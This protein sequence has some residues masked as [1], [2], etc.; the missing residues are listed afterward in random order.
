MSMNGLE[1]SRAYFSEAIRPILAERVP[2]ISQSYAAAL[3][4]WG[5]DVLGNDDELSR[6]HEWGPRCLLFV[7]GSLIRHKGK[8]LDELNRHLPME[9]KGHATR[10]VTD[11][12][13]PTVR[14]PTRDSAGRV[15]IEVTTC[16]EY[17][18]QSIGTVVPKS[19][20]EWLTIPE[21]T[22]LE[23][24][25][26]E[27]F[28]DGFGEL[29]RQRTYYAYFPLDVWKYRLAYTWQA[30]GWDIDLIG[31]C[32]MRGDILSARYGVSMSAYW[33][34]RLVFLLNR[35]YCPL[36]VKWF[37][38]E[39]YKLGHLA[40]EIGPVLEDSYRMDDLALVP[41]R[42][43]AAC[44]LLIEHQDSLGLLPN[45]ADMPHRSYRGFAY[46]EC[47]AIANRIKD[48]VEGELRD[49]SLDGALDQWVG[50]YDLLIEAGKLESLRKVYG[51]P[52]YTRT[53]PNTDVQ[54]HATRTTDH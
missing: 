38:R 46:A 11:T 39:F 16:D 17:L 54:Q 21:Q 6:D 33:I 8:V 50:N 1:L 18:T 40:G 35:R 42:L 30:F 5:S 45:C 20:I 7:P 13:N 41:G 28:R 15:H 24:T 49:V 32:A 12:A 29:T 3:L 27:V 47:Q 4:G 9:F 52:P 31:L 14:V 48:S 44:D 22:L 19:D 37:H 2:E 10:F 23:L 26:G 53:T 36:Y 34:M 43:T 51:A 25:R